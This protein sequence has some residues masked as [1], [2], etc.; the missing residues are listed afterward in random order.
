MDGLEM[1]QESIDRHSTLSDHG[2][3]ANSDQDEAIAEQI[4]GDDG[5]LFGDGSDEEGAGHGNL[6]VF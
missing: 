2:L 5:G 3:N 1:N 4:D 6:L